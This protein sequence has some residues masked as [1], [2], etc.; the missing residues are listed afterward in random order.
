[1]ARPGWRSAHRILAGACALPLLTLAVQ[2]AGDQL[3]ADPVEDLLHRTGLW[4]LRFLVA[5]LAVT[6]L[7]RQLGLPGLAPWR[8]TLGLWSFAY[9]SV[10]LSLWW[11]LDLEGDPGQVLEE[12]TKRP[13]VTVGFAAFLLLVPLAITSTR[14]WQRRLRGRWRRLHLL[15]H[16]A[17]LLAL[18]HFL[19]IEKADFT[20]PAAYAAGVGGLLLLRLS[21]RRV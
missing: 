15:V 6:P 9:A 19:W 7:R 17:I 2:A 14:S 1:M 16:P 8:R 10:H 5:S 21:H 13:Y 3:G 20:E 18:L 11:L 4:A 12:V